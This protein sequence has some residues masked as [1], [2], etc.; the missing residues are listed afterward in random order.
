M[1]MIEGTEKSD[2]E[3]MAAKTKWRDWPGSWS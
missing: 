2:W 1:S 3:K